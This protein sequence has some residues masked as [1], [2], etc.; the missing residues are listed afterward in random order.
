MRPLGMWHT[1]AHVHT[2]NKEH[3]FSSETAWSQHLII[4]SSDSSSII[5]YPTHNAQRGMT[6]FLLVSFISALVYCERL[7][8]SGGEFTSSI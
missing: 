2:K 3:L 4:L 6:G 1:A 7:F 5:N 8:C